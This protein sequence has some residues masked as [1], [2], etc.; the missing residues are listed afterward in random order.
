MCCA[1][2]CL[3]RPK[4]NREADFGW[5]ID[6]SDLPRLQDCPVAADICNHGHLPLNKQPFW[7]VALVLFSHQL[8]RRAEA[9]MK[10]AQEPSGPD[11]LLDACVVRLTV[12]INALP[13]TCWG[14]RRP[15]WS[16]GNTYLAADLASFPRGKPCCMSPIPMLHLAVGVH[17]FVIGKPIL[18]SA[19]KNIRQSPPL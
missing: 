2:L 9:K 15:Y 6:Q 12:A 1:N 16:E 14:T 17:A 18:A 5:R 10:K 3:K 7:D 13:Y 11:Q 19:S 8:R 4:V